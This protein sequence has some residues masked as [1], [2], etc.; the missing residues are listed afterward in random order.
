[1]NVTSN[2]AVQ[3]TLRVMR[4]VIRLAGLAPAPELEISAEEFSL[5]QVARR[6]LSSA[7]SIE[8]KYEILVA[9]FLALETQILDIAATNVVRNTLTY[10]EFFETRSALNVRMVNLLT[11]ARLYLDQLPQDIADCL[12]SNDTVPSLV[13]AR[14]SKEYDQHFEYRFMEALRNHAQHRGIP[15]HFVSQGAHWTSHDEYGRM[16]FVVDI[17][18]QRR[19][20]EE[21]EKFKKLILEEVSGDVDL[22]AACRR[23]IESLSAINQFARD[24]IAESVN[25]SRQTIEGA[26]KRYSE[27]Y[28]G[29]L[30]GLSAMALQ[31]GRETSS[32]PLLLD[33]DDV[34]LALQKRNSQLVNLRKRYAT[35]RTRDDRSM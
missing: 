33:W 24:L 34:R 32:V 8:E 30:L 3:G 31:D 4:H 29:N 15:I 26:H 22:T 2:P 1:M 13:K 9:N 23:Y 21:D 14:C 16:E 6:I 28:S 19:Y 18:A 5:L 7:F 35:G 11:A 25:G 12:P 17:V 10:S 27:L 20:L